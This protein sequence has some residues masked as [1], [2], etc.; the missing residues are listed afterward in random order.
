VNS[1]NYTYTWRE[2][3]KE[4]DRND[5]WIHELKIYYKVAITNNPRL[6]ITF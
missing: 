5:L 4:Q 6:V 2:I 1:S 3:T